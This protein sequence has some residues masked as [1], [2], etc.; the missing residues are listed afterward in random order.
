MS[1]PHDPGAAARRVLWL[2][3]LLP[4]AAAVVAATA[5]LGTERRRAA[6]AE[7]VAAAERAAAAFRAAR[8][9]AGSGAKAAADTA[10]TTSATAVDA[11][12]P[13]AGLLDDLAAS[14]YHAAL[15]LDGTRLHAVPAGFAPEAPPDGLIAELERRDGAHAFRLPDGRPAAAA[16]LKDADEWDVVGAVLVARAG[17]APPRLPPAALALGALAWLVTLP[18][19]RTYRVPAGAARTAALFLP[20]AAFALWTAQGVAAAGGRT[21]LPLA[22]F[23]AWGV[24]AAIGISLTRAATAPLHLRRAAAAWAFLAPSFIHLLVFSVGPILFSAWLSFHEWNLIEPARP[25]VGLENYREL[26]ADA[27]FWNAVRNTA[28]YVLFVPAGMALAL[29]LALLVQRERPGVRWLRAVFFLPYVTSF[30]A[31]SL[32]W[33][34]MFEPDFGILNQALGTLGLPGLP[35][36]TSPRT[37]LPSLML[38]SIWMYAGYMMV[39]FLAG[40]QA[41]PASLHEAARIDGANAWQRFRHITLPLLRPTTLFV[42]VTMVIFMFQVFTAVYVMTEGGPLHATDVLVYH[43]YRNAWEYLR[44][45]YASA[46]AWVLFA[47][48]FVATLVQLRWLGGRSHEG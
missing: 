44:M 23:G 45:G 9:D 35:W 15:Y 17:P 22:V 30:V 14:G 29:A 13:P 36:L 34:W 7:D 31:I 40:L 28:V 43:I 39:L 8:A 10:A 24:L 11:A 3:L 18:L 21:A 5:F 16:P 2:T 20:A 25:F 6:A 38:M 12:L 32:V 33:K 26:A 37:A 4:L 42:L 41:I 1:R 19:A 47:I 48:V 27:S 46:M